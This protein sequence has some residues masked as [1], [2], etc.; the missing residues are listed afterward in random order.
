MVPEPLCEVNNNECFVLIAQVVNEPH[1]VIQVAVVIIRV[2]ELPLIGHAEDLGE[3]VPVQA[4]GR[5][6]GGE[7]MGRETAEGGKLSRPETR[8]IGWRGRKGST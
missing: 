8:G 1:N 2:L 7:I 4:K 5:N 3:E 6:W